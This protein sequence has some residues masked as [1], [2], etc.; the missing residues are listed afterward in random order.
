ML[1]KAATVFGFT[2]YPPK[3]AA[4]ISKLNANILNIPVSSGPNFEIQG[5]RLGGAGS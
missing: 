5:N 1:V 3:S 4:A 2:E